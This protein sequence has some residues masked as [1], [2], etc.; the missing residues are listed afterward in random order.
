MHKRLL[1]RIPL[2]YLFSLGLLIS[3]TKEATNTPKPPRNIQQLI[4]SNPDF[5]FFNEAL[6]RTNLASELGSA[7]SFTVFAPSDNAF[8]N[9]GI[10]TKDTIAYLNLDTLK[11]FLMH[12][13]LPGKV[14]FGIGL[15]I[16][17]LS[18]INTDTSPDTLFVTQKSSPNNIFVNGIAASGYVITATNGVIYKM[19]SVVSI[20]NQ[21]IM[22]LVSTFTPID[23]TRKLTFLNK[24]L[25]ITGLDAPLSGKIPYTLFAPTDSAFARAGYR[26]L[27]SFDTTNI[28]RLTGILRVHILN[29]RLFTCD[30]VLDSLA[31][32]GGN[33]IRFNLSNPSTGV[34]LSGSGIMPFGE[35]NF[36]IR[37]VP[38]SNGVVHV[39]DQVLFP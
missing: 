1:F 28:N 31:S 37:D 7:T 36:L 13:I 24:A 26:D 27:Q 32:S 21:S 6:N 2:I 15:G 18:S 5:T 39:I 12:H 35:A 9:A 30:M 17:Y 38:A 33:L 25:K 16:P 10:R 29:G 19:G 8:M 20:P 4:S 14:S 3:C 34:S 22:G 11:T 23:S